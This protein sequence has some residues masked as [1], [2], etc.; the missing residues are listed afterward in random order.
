MKVSYHRILLSSIECYCLPLVLLVKTGVHQQGNQPVGF[1]FF[2]S[3]YVLF[4]PLQE[5][6]YSLLLSRMG[7]LLF[8]IKVITLCLHALT[9]FNST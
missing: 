6:E 2:F 9:E 4:M 1:V 5:I 3:P 8:R 7:S